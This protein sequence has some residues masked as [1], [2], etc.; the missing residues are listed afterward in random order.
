MVHDPCSDQDQT[1][2]SK[3][4]VVLSNSDDLQ[5]KH[6]VFPDSRS[7]EEEKLSTVS[8]EDAE[9]NEGSCGPL[10]LEKA[11]NYSKQP[12]NS[13][14]THFSDGNADAAAPVVVPEPPLEQ[15]IKDPTCTLV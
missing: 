3:N 11:N 12:Q 14:P 1:C 8:V 6:V 5:K 2:Q 9:M 15:G 13:C 4:P 10:R 7:T